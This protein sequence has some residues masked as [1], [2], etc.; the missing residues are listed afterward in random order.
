[1]CLSTEFFK[2]RDKLYKA[3]QEKGRIE[4][5]NFMKK[6]SITEDDLYKSGLVEKKNIC[7][8][9]DLYHFQLTKQGRSFFRKS[10]MPTIFYK[11][12]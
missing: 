9:A 11:S 4:L 7:S 5:D 1:M 12:K 8:T 3:Y 6:N 10:K 2:T